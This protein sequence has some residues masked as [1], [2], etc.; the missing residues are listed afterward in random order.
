[1]KKESIVGET[2]YYRPLF[3]LE[4]KSSKVDAIKAAKA[5]EKK[6]GCHVVMS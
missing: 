1:M 6:E 5:T 2:A 4:F 3:S